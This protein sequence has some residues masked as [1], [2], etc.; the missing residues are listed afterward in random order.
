MSKDD[1]T[2]LRISYFF[3]AVS[4]SYILWRFLEIVGIYS[5]FIERYTA[6]KPLGVSLSLVL[7]GA[8]VFFL[9]HKKTR[10]Q[11]YLSSIAELRK[12]VWPNYESTKKMTFIV[13][14]VVIFF[15]ILL[16]VFD[17]IWAWLLKKILV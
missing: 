10:H 8:V 14:S 9:A 13:I 11:Y 12:V 7:G 2:W 16:A 3:L 17:S 6:Y 4:I 5:N 15:T 1:L